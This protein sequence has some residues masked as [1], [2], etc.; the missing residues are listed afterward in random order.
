MQET[1]ESPVFVKMFDLVAWV[2]PLSVKFPR[3]QRF[4]LA[5]ALQRAAFHAHETLIRAGQSA[6]PTE[7]L[8]HLHEVGTQLALVRLYLRLSERQTLITARQYEYA[9]EQLGAI[10]RLVRAWQRTCQRKMTVPVVSDG[11]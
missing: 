4:V 7:A 2:I 1:Q 8:A 9:A 6:T 3:E 5:R 10:G 11:Q